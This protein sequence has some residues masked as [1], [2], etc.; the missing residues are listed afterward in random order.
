MET[1][2]IFACI[3]GAIG[4]L[5]ALIYLPKRYT[6]TLEA[7]DIDLAELRDT[8]RKT[9]AQ[10]AGGA[11]LLITFIWTITKDRDTIDLARAQAVNQ[12]F[13]EA[14]KLLASNDGKTGNSESRAAAIYSME[15]I[16]D[17]RKEYRDPVVNTL[18]S[19]IRSRVQNKTT[20]ADY[21][22]ALEHIDL[23]L[24]AALYVIG[25]IPRPPK[26]ELELN[27]LYL[28]GGV[29]S[30]QDGRSIGYEGARFR[31]SK[32]HS[33]NFRNAKL[34]GAKFEG[35]D[36]ADWQ[37]H[38]LPGWDKM[39]G[40]EDWRRSPYI[41]SFAGANLTNAVFTN[42]WVEGASFEGADVAR[43]NF[44]GTRIGR[45]VFTD[46]KNL[47]TASFKGAC[48]EGRFKPQGLPENIL[49]GLKVCTPTY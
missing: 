46:A 30:S 3:G 39:E 14:A 45:A 4:F 49:K 16:V 8:Y 24:K 18:L 1:W 37:S 47:P 44:E 29:F 5:A 25:R 43:A 13:A 6:A 15:H 26:Q 23:D 20:P 12:Q 17:S 11:A 33:A 22:Q 32:L 41:I 38:G 42:V 48:Y 7:S 10:V 9:I 31:G 21:K 19:L 27:G 36:M 34:T 35:A 40:S 2:L 28:V